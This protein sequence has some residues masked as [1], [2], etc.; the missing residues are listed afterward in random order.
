[1]RRL[2]YEARRR[3]ERRLLAR[4]RLRGG[5]EANK[6]GLDVGRVRAWFRDD[7]G[8]GAEWIESWTDGRPVGVISLREFN[9]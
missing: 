3:R 1:M 9:P 8:W 4:A 2:S 6:R 5:R 7:G